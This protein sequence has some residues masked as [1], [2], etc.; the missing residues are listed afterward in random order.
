MI[1]QK[2]EFQWL[3]LHGK[4]YTKWQ[5]LRRQKSD[6][7][8]NYFIAFEKQI[9]NESVSS[10]LKSSRKLSLNFSSNRNTHDN[11]RHIEFFW[12]MASC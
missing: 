1:S 8:I 6:M 10:N 5:H 12:A 11:L 4:L 2:S 7:Q 3:S 9:A